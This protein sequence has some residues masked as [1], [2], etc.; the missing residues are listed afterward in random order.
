MT[1]EIIK[2]LDALF[3]RFGI[4][5]DWTAENIMPYFQMFMARYVRYEIWRSVFVILISTIATAALLI[6][7]IKW[8][9]KDN[10]IGFYGG[11]DDPII[12]AWIFFGLMALITGTCL[13][14]NG[15]KIIG[16]ITFPEKVFF[17][18]LTSSIK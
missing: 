4:A 6:I 18:F 2:L 10:D 14:I 16:C 7:L 9:K 13:V 11:L 1:D 8:H 3:E 5:V 15:E 17:D 12:I